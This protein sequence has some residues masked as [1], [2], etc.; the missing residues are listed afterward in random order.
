[1]SREEQEKYYELVR[2]ERQLHTQ[3]YPGSSQETQSV[4]RRA[5]SGMS[6]GHDNYWEEDGHEEALNM[7]RPSPGPHAGGIDSRPMPGGPSGESEGACSQQDKMHHIKKP[8]NAFMLYIN[9]MLP[10]IVA[11]CPHI[12]SAAINQILG[13]RVGYCL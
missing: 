8:L 12:E 2:I 6:E 5:Q 13:G 7:E 10:K 3:M 4:N 11:E 9:E 1:M